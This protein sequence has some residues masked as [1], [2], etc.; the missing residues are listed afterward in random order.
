MPIVVL[1]AMS[2]ILYCGI[3]RGQTT[4]KFSTEPLTYFLGHF[5]WISRNSRYLKKFDP[6]I[7]VP[8]DTIVEGIDYLALLEYHRQQGADVTMLMK[9]GF[10]RGSNTRAYTLDGVRIVNAGQY[11]HPEWE[12]RGCPADMGVNLEPGQRTLTHD[13]TYVM[14]RRF[15]EMPLWNVFWQTIKPDY[16]KLFKDIKFVAYVTNGDWTDIRDPQNLEKVRSEFRK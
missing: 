9:E 5:T 8:V 16:A 3:A 12:A 13:G 2:S 10:K 4:T 15:F 6:I 11:L 7:F 1:I 14:G